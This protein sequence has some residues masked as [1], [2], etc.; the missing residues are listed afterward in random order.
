M[1]LPSYIT[2]NGEEKNT[3]KS[4]KTARNDKERDMNW[5]HHPQNHSL[6]W[7][8]MPVEILSHWYFIPSAKSGETRSQSLLFPNRR[9]RSPRSVISF[10]RVALY[11]MRSS[12]VSLKIPTVYPS[13]N[14][15]QCSMPVTFLTRNEWYFLATWPLCSKR[16]KCLE[17]WC[18]IRQPPDLVLIVGWNPTA[19]RGSP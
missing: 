6:N 10:H 17:F 13:L 8:L 9:G 3:K 11:F 1:R 15:R 4:T 16:K 19:L 5:C 2:A 14:L 12:R 18:M 7:F